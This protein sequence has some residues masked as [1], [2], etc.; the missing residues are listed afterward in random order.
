MANVICPNCGKT[1]PDDQGF[2]AFC[3][4][5]LLTDQVK[6]ADD[7]FGFSSQDEDVPDWLRELR[8]EE[9]EAPFTEDTEQGVGEAA[10]LDWQA[11]IPESETYP[12]AQQSS[13]QP[14]WLQ[15]LGGD[16]D[17]Q[18]E[19]PDRFDASESSQENL[20]WEQ[21]ALEQDSWQQDSAE[22]TSS[23]MPSDWLSSLTEQTGSSIEAGEE[24]PWEPTAWESD[25]WEKVTSR[26]ATSEPISE[27]LP[28]WLSSYHGKE[29]LS[30]GAEESVAGEQQGEGELV[31]DTPDWLFE[32]GAQP[33][34][35]QE[36]LPSE[37]SQEAFETS[38]FEEQDETVPDWMAGLNGGVAEP[39]S[40]VTPAFI[41]DEESTNPFETDEGISAADAGSLDA[42]VPDWLS[43]V[44]AEDTPPS[45]G[46]PSP[47][48]DA[49]LAPVDLPEW[50][51]AMRPVESAAPGEA[52]RDMS[53]S[54]VETAGPLA[55]LRG[56]L[57]AEVDLTSLRKPAVYS[58]QLEI[59]PEQQARVAL[60][61]EML[62]DEKKERPTPAS[63]MIS[64]QYILRLLILGVLILAA[65][66]AL[67]A[68]SFESQGTSSVTTPP[69]VLNLR[70]RVEALAAGA[71]VLVAVDYEPG[72]S[73]EMRAAA[74]AVLR[75]LV[76]RNAYLVFVSST[77]SGPV[78]AESLIAEINLSPEGTQNTFDHYLN[79][80][81]IPGGPSGLNGF[82]QNPSQVLPYELT[83]GKPAWSGA[84]L[85]ADR[86]LASFQMAL[87]IS[88]NPDTARAWLEQV[89]PA[90]QKENISFGLVISAQADPLVRPYYLSSG[91]RV[92]GLVSGLMGGLKYESLSNWA[93]PAHDYLS[94]YSATLTIAIVLIVLG[95]VIHLL[96]STIAQ[97]R[98][99]SGEEKA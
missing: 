36:A 19:S 53:D 44:S 77:P 42:S 92:V 37:N 90:L 9:S 4:E 69:E 94:A 16:F 96:A 18:A 63:S 97:N 67:W 58:T 93:G 1:T 32:L 33:F 45:G 15:R 23:D 60:L 3:Q 86:G 57:P 30:T 11:D 66:W 89:G 98:S 64:P 10:A 5:P 91:G 88:E 78:L 39:V 74:L 80:G 84:P 26:P 31:S 87:V 72:Y 25:A 2:C 47:T 35:E 75:H 70:L 28:D 41:L 95:I 68:G 20:P 83:E 61:E 43:Q 40:G 49:D 38:D 79:L 6:D 81:Y 34:A 85:D 17:V 76:E 22:E 12:P 27:D 99:I 24:A 7:L 82:A 55:G 73:G 54:R 51:E 71:P 52:F 29:D 13:D 65:I 14:D 62:R 8:A 46:A 59:M 56:A 48:Q 50:L 21:A